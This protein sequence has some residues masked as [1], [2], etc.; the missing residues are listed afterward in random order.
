MG[1]RLLC[2]VMY[3]DSHHIPG[4]REAK[5]FVTKLAL[6]KRLNVSRNSINRYLKE[7]QVAGWLES[8]DNMT[9]KLQT[10]ILNPQ[11]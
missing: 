6:E 9:T 3:E 8:P 2:V 5:A 10:W 11:D 1:A 4:D 7:L